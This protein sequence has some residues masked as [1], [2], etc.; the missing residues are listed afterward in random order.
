MAQSTD[1]NPWLIF[2]L[3]R[4]TEVADILGLD[5]PDDPTKADI[6]NLLQT[7]GYTVQQGQEAL[8]NY[9]AMQHT[10]DQLLLQQQQQQIQPTVP[11]HSNKV[12]LARHEASESIDDFLDRVDFH[13]QLLQINGPSAVAALLNA[14]P[15]TV[16]AFVQELFEQGIQEPTAILSR[17]R[18]KFGANSFQALA[19]FQ[20]Y[21]LPLN[22]TAREAA[23]AL[24][25]AYV[26]YLN[27]PSADI[28]A[29]HRLL[30]KAVL[31]QLLTI[32]PNQVANQTKAHCLQYPDASMD[33]IITHID[34]LLAGTRHAGR[35]TFQQVTTST[36]ATS[37]TKRIEDPCCIPGHKY[38]SNAQCYQQQRQRTNQGNGHTGSA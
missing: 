16:A 23:A 28:T 1:P 18:T 12:K 9:M 35:R 11:P 29:G 20:A 10:R 21:R 33:D 3:T 34:I 8:S 37:S 5:L 22:G 27:L 24:S 25:K 13:F 19:S 14:A 7:A 30:D 17:V 32:L 26:R 15:P 38:H 2:N 36:G 4:L 31:C 6:A